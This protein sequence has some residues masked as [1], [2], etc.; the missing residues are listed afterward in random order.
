MSIPYIISA[1]L[2]PIMGICVDRYGM[3]AVIA[4]IAPLLLVAVHS[5]L[6][7]SNVSPIGG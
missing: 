6:A 2:S 7:A 4:T 3:R 1:C 5:L